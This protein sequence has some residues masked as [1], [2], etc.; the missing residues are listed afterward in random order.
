MGQQPIAEKPMS[1]GW[2][3][4]V[5]KRVAGAGLEPTREAEIVEE[6]TQ[7]LEE[8][9][10]ELL[11]AGTAPDAVDA[12]LLAELDADEALARRLRSAGP[13]ATDPPRL[14]ATRGSRLADLAA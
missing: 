14:G 8:R 6:L 7:H 2:R 10:A 5:R 4:E 9:R 13:R 3:V 12:A 1:G 11:A